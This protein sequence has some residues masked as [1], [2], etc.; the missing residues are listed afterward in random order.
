MTVLAAG[1][2]A[3]AC[4]PGVPG[5]LEGFGERAAADEFRTQLGDDSPLERVGQSA[6]WRLPL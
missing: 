3:L 4:G 1:V 2:G 6:V 5:N